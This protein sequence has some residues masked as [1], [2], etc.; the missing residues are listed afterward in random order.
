MKKERAKRRR[1]GVLGW[2]VTSWGLFGLGRSEWECELGPLWKEGREVSVKMCWYGLGPRLCKKLHLFKTQAHAIA[3][4]VARAPT[5]LIQD[6]QTSGCAK[7]EADTGPALRMGLMGLVGLM[8][9]PGRGKVGIRKVVVTE[10]P[11]QNPNSNARVRGFCPA[12]F[13]PRVQALTE[14]RKAGALGHVRIVAAR[15]SWS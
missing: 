2:R 6:N 11:R 14:L 10:V 1:A 7:I 8:G 3:G 9:L 4:V 15:R 12:V 5:L 13:L